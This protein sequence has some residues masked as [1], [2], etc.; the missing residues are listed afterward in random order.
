M[1]RVLAIFL[2]LA[3]CT[4]SAVLAQEPNEEKPNFAEPK[5]DWKWDEDKRFD[6][7]MERLA[8]LEASLDAVDVAITKASCKKS[9]K[10]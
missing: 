6:F 10:H 9:A 2:G 5:K 3:L 1:S 7:L 8:R 4:A